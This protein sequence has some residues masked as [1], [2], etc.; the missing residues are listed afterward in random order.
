[1]G[2]F[3]T[4]TLPASTTEA[5]SFVVPVGHSD[6]AVTTDSVPASL[7]S[8]AVGATVDLICSLASELPLD[9]FRGEHSDAH[10]DGYRRD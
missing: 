1:M 2:L 4:A 10:A 6:D 3:R 5:R 9:V 8:V 7:Q